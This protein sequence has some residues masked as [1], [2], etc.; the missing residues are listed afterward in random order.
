MCAPGFLPQNI[1]EDYEEWLTGE[2]IEVKNPQKVGIRWKKIEIVGS[3]EVDK[4][5]RK[6]EERNLNGK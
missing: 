2:Y 5:I 1:K 4:P 3:I 6:F